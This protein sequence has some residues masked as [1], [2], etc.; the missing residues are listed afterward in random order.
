MAQTLIW[1]QE[2]LN[3]IDSIAEYIIGTLS[4]MHKTLLRVSF[5]GGQFG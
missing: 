2:A 4:I 3:D 1:S 5:F